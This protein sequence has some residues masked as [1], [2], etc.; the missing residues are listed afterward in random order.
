MYALRV[1][2]RIGTDAA[3]DLAAVRCQ[4]A[5]RVAPGKITPRGY[6]T[7]RQQAATLEQ[8][9]QCARVH[10]QRSSRTQGAGY[11]LLASLGQ[12]GT[13]H[14]PGAPAAR[15]DAAQRIAMVTLGNAQVGASRDGDTRR[16][17]LWGKLA[18]RDNAGALWSLGVAAVERADLPAG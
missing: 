2:Q 18:E 9:G 10:A 1:L 7:R 8:R 4:H 5:D 14:E 3:S 6:Q 15:L 16:H 13:R 11:P 17:V 12:V